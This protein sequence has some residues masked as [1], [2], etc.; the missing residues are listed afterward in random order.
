MRAIPDPIPKFGLA[1]L[2]PKFKEAFLIFCARFFS[3]AFTVSILFL[4]LP[5]SEIV[6]ALAN[7]V[8]NSLFCATR[9]FI[10]F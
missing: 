10:S 3:S 2:P 7:L 4:K 1:A 9:S 6:P 5:L 8:S